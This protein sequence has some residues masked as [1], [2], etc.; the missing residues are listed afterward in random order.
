MGRINKRWIVERTFA[1]LN[2]SRRF[3]K[4][5]ELRP[6]SAETMIYIAFAQM[7]IYVVFGQ[8]LRYAE[9]RSA[10]APAFGL[11]LPM[12]R[13]KNGSSYFGAVAALCFKR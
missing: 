1:W 11:G 13:G 6:S 2:W 12:R 5:Y 8:T 7:T 10:V 3:S 4:D 9:S